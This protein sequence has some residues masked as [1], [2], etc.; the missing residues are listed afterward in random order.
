MRRERK[1]A[2]N[3]VAEVEQNETILTRKAY[4]FDSGHHHCWSEEAVAGVVGM[5]EREEGKHPVGEGAVGGAVVVATLVVMEV[6]YEVRE[7]SR[8]SR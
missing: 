2:P 8:V 4:S 3:S 7:V 5:S 1:S 6:L